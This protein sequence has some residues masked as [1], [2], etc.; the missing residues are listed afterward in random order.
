MEAHHRNFHH[1]FRPY[2][3]QVDLMNAIYDCIERK[4]VGLFESPTGTVSSISHTRTYMLSLS[5][6]YARI[7]QLLTVQWHA[8]CLSITKFTWSWAFLFLAVN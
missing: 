7:P 2:K 8:S 1:P 6:C 4:Q 5:Q 3:I